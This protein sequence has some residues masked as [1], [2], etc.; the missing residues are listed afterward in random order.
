VLLELSVAAD[1]LCVDCRLAVVAHAKCRKVSGCNTLNT[2]SSLHLCHSIEVLTYT[3]LLEL[4]WQ[5]S[6][7]QQRSA[8]VSIRQV[9]YTALLELT[10]PGV[11]DG[12]CGSTRRRRCLERGCLAGVQLACCVCLLQAF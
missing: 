1:A 9:A 5:V 6:I 8:Y 11:Q 4:T 12:A 2:H 7:R 10:L 3:A